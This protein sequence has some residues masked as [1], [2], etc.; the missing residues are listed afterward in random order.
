MAEPADP[1]AALAAVRHDLEACGPIAALNCVEQH[2]PAMVAGYAR[3]LKLH[4]G[5]VMCVSCCVPLAQCPVRR[6]I[7]YAL[8]RGA[9]HG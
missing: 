5:R 1:D 2:M 3:L 6:I 9:V 8:T 4:G 7:L